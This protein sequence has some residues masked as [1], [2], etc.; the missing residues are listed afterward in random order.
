MPDQRSRG[1]RPLPT[2]ERARARLKERQRAES[3]KLSAV[4]AAAG[5]LDAQ[6][7]RYQEKV[8]EALA[9][10]REREG[11]L[12][13]AIAELASACGPSRAAVLLDRDEQ[14]MRKL[15]RRH[16]GAR[17]TQTPRE[18]QRLDEDSVNITEPV[19][20]TTDEQPLP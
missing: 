6:R 12:N 17:T 7:A 20:T 10:V 15:A 18:L 11:E 2:S 14:E 16:S 4:L 19:E 3:E 8:A 1:N 13:T 9:L 5:R